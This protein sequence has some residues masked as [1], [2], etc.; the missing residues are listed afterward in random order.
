[1]SL[2]KTARAERDVVWLPVVFDALARTFRAKKGQDCSDRGGIADALE[3]AAHARKRNVR[4]KVLQIHVDDD[5][6]AGMR[7]RVREDRA[8]RQ[9][10]GGRRL[11]GQSGYDLA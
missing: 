6:L 7:P 9:E 11:D 10:P 4:E 1:S 2:G 5:G 3:N 8:A